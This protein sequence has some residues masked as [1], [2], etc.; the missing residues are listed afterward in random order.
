MRANT[1]EHRAHMR[2]NFPE[3]FELFYAVYEGT[4]EEVIQRLEAGDNSNARSAQGQTPVFQA[5]LRAKNLPK[6]DALFS[7]GA[8]LDVWDNWGMHPLHHVTESVS[9]PLYDHQ[10]MIWLLDHGIDSN[11][12][13]R[14]A[15]ETPLRI[16]AGW[17]PLHI[18][19]N[20]NSLPII[21]FLL[22]R[23]ANPHSRAEDGA[24]PLH[25]AAQQHK[26]YKRLIRT[27]IDA[28]ADVNAVTNEG[29]T[30]LHKVTQRRSGSHSVEVTRFLLG[31][32]AR[33]DI[34]DVSGKLAIDYLKDTPADQELRTMLQKKHTE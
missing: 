16:Y 12:M 25:I 33:G 7:A 28:G 4:L 20:H 21:E 31:R 32:G 5:V 13:V 15:I 26:L 1:E 3:A 30:P 27:L 23:G 6:A 18:A 24:T 19:A 9:S 14:P 2:P 17:T 29:H 34:Q 8:D 22:A 11:L 10:C